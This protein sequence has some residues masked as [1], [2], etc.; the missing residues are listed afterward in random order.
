MHIN[1]ES[2]APVSM[3]DIEDLEEVKQPEIKKVEIDERIKEDD[4]VILE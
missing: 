4:V 3:D 2:T 1:E